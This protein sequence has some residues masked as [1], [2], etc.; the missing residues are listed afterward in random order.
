MELLAGN[1]LLFPYHRDFPHQAAL[2]ASSQVVVNLGMAG[3]ASKGTWVTQCA[4]D[5]PLP[6]H[7]S[8]LS[9]VQA[10]SCLLAPEEGSFL[11]ALLWWC[12]HCLP[13]TPLV[14]VTAAQ[15][16]GGFQRSSCSEQGW[17]T[18]AC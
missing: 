13:L 3:K 7:S 10:I 2:K 4:R 16:R 8:V 12:R 6:Q 11:G 14:C 17:L 5:I 9:H 1:M 18:L 15:A